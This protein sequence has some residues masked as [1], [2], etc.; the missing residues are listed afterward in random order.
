[1]A[2]HRNHKSSEE[3]F[4]RFSAPKPVAAALPLIPVFQATASSYF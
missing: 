3:G 2:F 1:M 4:A